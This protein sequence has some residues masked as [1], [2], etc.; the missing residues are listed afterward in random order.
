MARLSARRRKSMPASEFAGPGRSFPVNDAE[1]A[2][3]ALQL[4]PRSEKAGN[5]SPGAAAKVRARAHAKLGSE[6]HHFAHGRP[7]TD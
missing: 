4:L 6:P 2:R 7:R 5:I 3:K 1:H